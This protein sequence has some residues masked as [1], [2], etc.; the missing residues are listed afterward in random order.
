VREAADLSKLLD[1]PASPMPL[2]ALLRH[3]FA[4]RDAVLESLSPQAFGFDDWDVSVHLERDRER[5]CA[6]LQVLASVVL[7][8]A[9]AERE[10]LTAYYAERGLSGAAKPAIVDVGHRGTLQRAIAAL[11]ERKDVRGYYFA[12]VPDA[13]LG[14]LRAS[15]FVGFASEDPSTLAEYEPRLQLFELLFLSDEGSFV[16]IESRD[17]TWLADT[18]AADRDDN[19]KGFARAVHAGALQFIDDVVAG[20]GNDVF[21]WRFSAREALGP[22]LIRLAT[23][24]WSELS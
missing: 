10:S 1:L 9:A 5:L 6:L 21:E 2:R 8:A 22:L 7:P 17:G 15:S 20:P 16:R 23:K 14:Q 11:V 4:L 13:G 18:L 3:R 12:T 24:V 19:R